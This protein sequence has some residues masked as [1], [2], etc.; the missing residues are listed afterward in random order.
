[1]KYL[2]GTKDLK[3]C[4][5]SKSDLKLK[6]YADAD[7]PGDIKDRKSTSGFVFKLGD[8]AIS[9]AS[10]KQQNVTLSSTEAEF[11]SLAEVSQEFLCLIQLLKKFQINI[12]DPIIFEDNQSCLKMLQE[13]KI[14]PRSKHIDVK[15]YFVRNLL[16]TG[17]VLYEYCPT[18]S[19][20]A[21]ILTKPL[22]RIRIY[23]IREL[24]GLY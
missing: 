1:M 6:G 2:K 13:E 20:L 17:K 7:W 14:T 15:Y 10:R 21:D 11:V 24:I 3:L 23:K 5:G 9:Y 16:K 12:C 19:M 22:P 8:A 18:E 4:V